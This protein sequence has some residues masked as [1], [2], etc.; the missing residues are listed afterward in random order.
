LVLA[1]L[2]NAIIAPGLVLTDITM[3]YSPSTILLK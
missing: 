3:A 1:K 2:C